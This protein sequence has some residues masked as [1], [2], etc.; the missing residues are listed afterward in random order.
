[1]NTPLTSNLQ[2]LLSSSN[3]ILL[4][5]GPLGK[6]FHIFAQWL[7]QHGK[8]VYKLN[9]NSGDEFFYPQNCRNTFAYR[10]TYNAF[11]HFLSSFIAEHQIDAIVCFGDTRPYHQLAK[12]Y[13]DEHPKV[14]FWA[15]EEGYFRPSFITLEQSGV[16]AFS[17]LPT[18]AAFFQTAYSQLSQQQYIEPPAVPGGFRPT[19]KLAILY[20]LQTYLH[21]N[22]YP[23]YIHHRE[24]S[25]SHYMRLWVKSGLRRIKYW[26]QDHQFAKRVEKGEFG[27]FFILPLQVYND[28]QVRV[29][30]DFSSVRSFLHHILSSF[31][32][33]APADTT[34]IVK[35]HPMDRG[36]IDYQNDIDMFKHK[37]PHL[38]GRIFY[39]HDVPLPVL[40]RHGAGMV[41]L[42]ST[43]GLSA[44]IH[45][46]PVKVL[47]RCNYDIVGLTDQQKLADFWRHPMPPDANKFH[48]YRMYHINITQIHGSFYSQVN[49]PNLADTPI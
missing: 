21:K 15:F 48:A 49:L 3:N 4:L 34:L 44:L 18:D 39:I 36:F 24:S 32:N 40:L 28:S 23:H 26:L 1:M 16:N 31:A 25:I 9:F 27:R 8:T 46:M 43:A 30:S 35:H 12:A 17:K 19:A 20:Y 42:N 14:S 45:H 13:T 10:D 11:P 41:T 33:N 47:G 37:Y 29:H 2:R 7:H 38:A 22:R 5:Q 6:F